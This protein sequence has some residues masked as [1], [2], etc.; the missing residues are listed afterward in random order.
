MTSHAARVRSGPLHAPTA[1]L[2]DAIRRGAIVALLARRAIWM[3]ALC[4][5]APP[6]LATAALSQSEIALLERMTRGQAAIVTL[7]GAL[8]GLASIGGAPNRAPT[9]LSV[10]RGLS[11]L[12]DLQIAAR[13]RAAKYVE[14]A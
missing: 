11:R 5:V 6:T 12:A 1:G 9:P 7:G 3:T 4:R 2:A 10:A 13:L 14:R 8:A